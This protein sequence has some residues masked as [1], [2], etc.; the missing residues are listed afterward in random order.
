MQMQLLTYVCMFPVPCFGCTTSNSAE[1]LKFLDVATS[2]KLT[3][4]CTCWMGV[5]CCNK[6]LHQLHEIP[7]D[8]GVFTS[9]NTKHSQ[10]KISWEVQMALYCHQILLEWLEDARKNKSVQMESDNT[11]IGMDEKKCS[12][13]L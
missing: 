4:F 2:R 7:K 3:S 11:L 6:I 13:N 10:G 1:S 12:I 9:H 8:P 5:V